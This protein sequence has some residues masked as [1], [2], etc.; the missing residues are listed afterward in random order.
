MRKLMY[1]FILVFFTVG[2]SAQVYAAGTTDQAQALVKKAISF[3]KANGK[4]KTF[5]EINNSKG[6]FVKGDLYVTVYDM[7]GK[8]LAHGANKAMVGKDMIGMRDPDGVFMIKE[9]IAITKSK[10]HGWQDYKFTNPTT[11]KIE[12]KTAYVEKVDNYVFTC[13]AYKK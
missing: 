13:G 9:R 7:D 3:Y 4:D 8:C 6:Q 2:I 11:K 5:A 1:I 10:G 12:S